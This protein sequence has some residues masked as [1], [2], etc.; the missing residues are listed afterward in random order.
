MRKILI[1][2]AAVAGLMATQASAAS[3]CTQW[4]VS[5]MQL[6]QSNGYIVGLPTQ[7]S[8][9]SIAGRTNLSAFGW[10]WQRYVGGGYISGWTYQNR[11]TA[12]IWW[13]SGSAGDYEGRIDAYGRI[14]GT[15][16][17][18]ANYN[19]SASFTSTGSARCRY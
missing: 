15:T 8:G 17:D 6:R 11:F 12:T 9:T 2:L 5:W 3:A 14:T 18:R 4:D 19:S 16:H 7:S 10:N 1:T 13:D